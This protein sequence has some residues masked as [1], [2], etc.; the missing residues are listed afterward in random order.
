[1]KPISVRKTSG[2]TASALNV[3]AS[4]MPAEVMTAPVTASPRSMPMA[5]AV[6]SASP[7]ARAPSGRCCSRSPARPGRRTTAAAATG[8]RRGSRRRARRRRCPVPSAAKNDRITER[9]SSSGASSARSSSARIS[10][11]DEQ[12]ER[13]DHEVVA[14]RGLAVVVGLGRRAADQH[15]RRRPRPRA[16]RRSAGTSSNAAVENGS[17]L[18]TTSSRAPGGPSCGGSTWA[19]RSRLLA[20]APRA[21][22]PPSRGRARSRWSAPTG[23]SGTSG[24]GC[25]RPAPTRRR[26]GTSCRWSARCRSG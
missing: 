19:T 18:S 25:R 6:A 1:M 13:Q 10:E 7:R 11:H 12:R 17:C 3:P 9:T 26:R 23:R 22:R 8:R 24:R 2:S 5:R 4:T 14:R 15:A 21:P 16:I 20:A